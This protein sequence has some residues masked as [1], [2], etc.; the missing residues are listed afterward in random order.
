MILAFVRSPG[1]PAGSGLKA[2]SV[3]AEQA[4]DRELAGQATMSGA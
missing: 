4:H 2:D 1:A 3:V